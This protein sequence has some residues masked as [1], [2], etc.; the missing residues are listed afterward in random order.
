MK[1]SYILRIEIKTGNGTS[2][3]ED[4]VPSL[5]DFTV[6]PDVLSIIFNNIQLLSD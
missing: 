3:R 2:V 4:F 6:L 5:R 1:V